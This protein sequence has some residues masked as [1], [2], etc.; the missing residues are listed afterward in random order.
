MFR[1]CL[2]VKSEMSTCQMHC[3]VNGV[4]ADQTYDVN[5]LNNSSTLYLSTVISGR[6][7]EAKT[8]RRRCVTCL[9]RCPPCQKLETFF[10]GGYC[11]TCARRIHA[12]AIILTPNED[13][14]SA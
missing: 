9:I 10:G 2:D 3:Y 8:S 11:S 13:E 14:P 1:T 12:I 6:Q 5:I 4:K 7:K